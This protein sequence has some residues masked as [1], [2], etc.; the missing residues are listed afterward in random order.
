MNQEELQKEL[1]SLLETFSVEEAILALK[2]RVRA[3]ESNTEK[4]KRYRNTQ[5]GKDATRL[6]SKKYYY[7]KI[8]KHHPIYNPIIPETN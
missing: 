1:D 6:A 4:M 5:K 7:R 3:R 8:K 2:A